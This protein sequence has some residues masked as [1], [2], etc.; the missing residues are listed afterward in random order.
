MTFA[1][2]T[3]KQR[4]KARKKNYQSLISDRSSKLCDILT[5]KDCKATNVVCS[6]ILQYALIY[7]N[8][9]I[10]NRKTEN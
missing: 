4:R 2:I 3:A 9:I 6:I 7:N 10:Q 5:Q 8:A 1:P